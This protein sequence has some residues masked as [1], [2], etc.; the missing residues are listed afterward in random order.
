MAAASVKGVVFSPKDGARIGA[1]VRAF[2][3]QPGRVPLANGYQHI[4][5]TARPIIFELVSETPD[6]N[7]RF[8][9]LL[10]QRKSDG[11]GYEAISTLQVKMEDVNA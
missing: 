9:V 2:E 3:S 11:T 10:M 7:G 1:A 5:S 8:T 6:A 4:K